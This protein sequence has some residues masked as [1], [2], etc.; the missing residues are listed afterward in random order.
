MPR[1]STKG[2]RQLKIIEKSFLRTC[3]EYK[4]FPAINLAGKWLGDIGF[5]CGK[6]VSVTYRKNKL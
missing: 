5:D 2:Q 4:I 6:Q 3:H 1:K